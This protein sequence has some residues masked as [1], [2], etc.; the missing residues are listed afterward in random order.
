MGS[1]ATGPSSPITVGR[2][3]EE[4]VNYVPMNDTL[5]RGDRAVEQMPVGENTA[6]SEIA[7]L[8][9]RANGGD[10]AA[11]SILGDHYR[12]GDLVLQDD[13]MAFRWYSRG[14]DL[15]DASAQ[16]NL[17]SMLLNAIGCERAPN[18]A[19]YWYRKSAE[20][21]LAIA[22]YNLGKRYYHGDG[23]EQDYAEARKWLEKAANQGESWASCE[24]GTMYWLGQGVER[25]L[26]A[27]ADFHLI[28][29]EGGDVLACQNLATYRKKLERL[30]LSGNQ[31]ASLFLCRMYNR[32]FGADKSQ[33]MTWA[34]IWWA[35]KHCQTDT[36]LEI[37]EEVDEAYSFYG[38][39]I[40]LEDRNLGEHSLARMREA[41]RKPTKARRKLKPTKHLQ[42]S[43]QAR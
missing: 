2:Y 30:A 32:G 17:G 16:N 38:M 8:E 1:V 43:K 18:Q 13:A 37:A 29:A 34:W 25:N 24:I 28:A 39:C 33:S 12:T 36:D 42:H 7:E 11:A 40:S 14:A 21:G 31:M 4:H 20:Q 6:P 41:H 22:Q 35:K 27:A 5:K 26:L 19:V 3:S 9:Q 15:G 23:V 10:G